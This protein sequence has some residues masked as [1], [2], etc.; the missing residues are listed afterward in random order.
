MTGEKAKAPETIG[1]RWTYAGV[2]AA[3]RR[4]GCSREHLS[5]VLHGKRKANPKIARTLRHM[6]VKVGVA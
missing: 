5:K 3:A 2:A 1:H 6:G 4:I